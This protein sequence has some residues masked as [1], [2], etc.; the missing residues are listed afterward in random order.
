MPHSYPAGAGGDAD[1]GRSPHPGPPDFDPRFVSS[2]TPF[3]DDH[4]IRIADPTDRDG[5]LRPPG[6]P[7]LIARVVERLS[8]AGWS[9]SHR[10]PPDAPWPRTLIAH[11]QDAIVVL[12]ADGRVLFESPSASDIL[13]FASS[14]IIG[15][16]GFA[17]IHPD[18][19][20]GVVALFGRIVASPA[21]VA[22]CTYRFQ[23]GDGSW[24]HLE[25]LA[26][27]LLHDATIRGV[28]I[29]FRDV[30]ERARA[31][32][33][34]ER[35]SQVRDELL[36][37]V[38]HELRTPLHGMIGWA[39][40]LE[41]MVNE[42]GAEAI[43]QIIRA[44]ERLLKLVDDALDVAAAHEGRIR[45]EPYPIAA[46]RALREAADAI[47]PLA[48]RR[49]IEISLEPAEPH[50][51]LLLVDPDRFL[52]V[53][54][55]VLSN[56]VKYNRDG[57]RVRMSC[58]LR[59]H[60]ARI[61]I[62]DTGRG[63]PADRLHRLFERYDRL[64]LEESEAAGSGLGLAISSRFMELMGGTIGVE[65]TPEEGS[66]FHLEVPTAPPEPGW[67]AVLPAPGDRG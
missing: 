16:S 26:K 39:N 42:R 52:Q 66:R 28:V 1:S 27:N 6:S 5:S 47:L 10:A 2:P 56:A 23:R 55:N 37:R 60:R 67:P 24:Q 54:L 20:D 59:N 46:N 36:S 15:A 64:G 19:R 35:A 53:L 30:T 49:G 61:T 9:S 40:L 38:S 51:I 50:D 13:G 4:R 57:G 48:A 45:I 62:A 63:I 32:D 17:R 8:F 25:A 18:D 11:V 22:R 29:T 33:E 7:T 21:M 58:A 3:D 65:S 12:D 44:A 34:A 43:E 14:E 31:L 41:S